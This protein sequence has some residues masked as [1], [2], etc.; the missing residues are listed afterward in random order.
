[1]IEQSSVI[2][3]EMCVPRSGVFQFFTST[4]FIES[5]KSQNNIKNQISALPSALEFPHCL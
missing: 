5:V 4:V 1:M 2:P 3:N